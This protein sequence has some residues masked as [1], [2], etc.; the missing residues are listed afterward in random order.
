MFAGLSQAQ[1]A[2]DGSLPTDVNT[3]DNLNFDITGGERVGDN[4]F[5]SFSQF[6]VPTGGSV[7][8]NNTQDIQNIFS[9]VTGGSI[10]NIDG[11]IQ[12]NNSNLFLLN[13][14]GI[15][16][17]SNAELNIGGS[18]NATT[19]EQI[20]FANDTSLSATDPQ[21]SLLTLNIPI[22]LQFGKTPGQI[23]NRSA[24]ED[25]SGTTVGL[26]VP[27]GNTLALVGGDIFL[28]G[29]NL[30]AAGGRIE[31]KSVADDSFVGLA[32]TAEGWALGNENVQNFQDIRL[33][34]EASVD[35]SGE[36]SGDIILQGRRITIAESSELVTFND[37]VDSS[38]AIV[39]NASE[40]I[41]L[42]SDSYINTNAFSTGSSGDIEI[43]AKRLIV[44]NGSFIDTSNQE[45]GRGGNLTVNASESVEIDGNGRFSQLTTAT[46]FGESDAGDL[47]V[48]T[49]RLILRD[50]GLLSSSTNSIGNGGEIIINASES[51][52]IIGRGIQEESGVFSQ[53]IGIEATG[54]AG[55]IIID[56]ERLVLRGGTISV[57][58]VDGSNGRAGNLEV[59]ANSLFL[60]GGAIA[61][62]TARTGGEAGANINLKSDLLTMENQSLISATASGVVDGG[63][64][65]IDAD[66]VIAVPNQ[67]NDIIARAEQGTGGNID[68][69]TNGIFG[70]EE[71]GSTPSNNTNDID[72]SSEFGLDGTVAINE[73]DVNPIEAL[74]ELPAEIIDVTRLVAQN[75]C[76]QG[77]GS[78]FVVTGKG[79]TAPS[80]TQTRDGEVGVVDL[81]K[82][83]FSETGG[84]GE[85]GEDEAA[86]EAGGIVEAKGW[87]INDRGMVELVAQ[88]T[89]ADSVPQPKG[90]RVCHN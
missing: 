81:V 38:G 40:S 85:A 44:A 17:G 16:F 83:V 2:N 70:I 89:D 19:A 18:F 65:T 28:E 62:E 59:D 25:S 34:Q 10:S 79:G 29:G 66:F 88:K 5:H 12:T 86:G 61:A 67:N 37:G 13:P 78:E 90:D 50:G 68:I 47:K 54:N 80:P 9:R 27:P 39:V 43:E 33:S 32:S 7:N 6:S 57:A 84:A 15:I 73:L 24:V 76:Q 36:N 35:T 51:I 30:S 21:S 48:T 46:T 4:L 69:T 8:F 31:L 77:Q 45:N 14:N 63:N 49:Q 52:E 22:G 53:T 60:D 75:L 26:Q 42:L 64:I 58:A 11:L 55:D 71:R 74:E 87:I 72:P 23:I 20:D 82:P 56:T 3:S 41:E 1:V